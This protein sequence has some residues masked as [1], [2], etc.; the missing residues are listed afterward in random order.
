MVGNGGEGVFYE[1]KA[2]IVKPSFLSQ[3]E[4]PDQ[5]LAIKQNWQ[6]ELKF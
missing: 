1:M 4:G 2:V 6:I 3:D 5:H